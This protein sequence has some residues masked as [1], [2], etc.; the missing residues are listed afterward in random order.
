MAKNLTSF[1]R[2]IG[3][4]GPKTTGLNPMCVWDYMPTIVD[5]GDKG[6]Y[7]FNHEPFWCVPT[8]I[9]CARIE[10][11]GAGG[12][13]A[14]ACNCTLAG[15]SG[16]GAYVSKMITTVPGECYRIHL[17]WNYCT[18]PPSGG[19]NT[20]KHSVCTV[21]NF[22]SWATGTGLTNFC[23]EQ[24]CMAVAK[25]CDTATG[26]TL[27]YVFQD[28]AGEGARF[29]GG[30]CGQRGR[31]GWIELMDS[32]LTVNEWANYRQGIPYP[33]GQI[34]KCGGH[35]VIHAM[36]NSWCSCKAIDNLWSVAA[37]RHGTEGGGTAPG[38]TNGYGKMAG[39][40][41]PSPIDCAGSTACCSNGNTSGRARISFSCCN[42]FAE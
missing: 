7:N 16:S 36:G 32:A 34:N 38:N 23:A 18:R 35:H 15:P 28:S 9:T 21:A 20:V 12:N 41:V 5:A 39:W 19:S 25:C 29:F 40:G 27:K 11:W 31:A 1:V 10:L 30:D 17:G 2:S 14:G 42:T 8:G 4:G 3:A 33:G 6:C 26:S 22:N 24:G 37:M 13:G